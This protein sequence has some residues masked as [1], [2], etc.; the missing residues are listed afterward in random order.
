[1]A[2]AAGFEDFYRTDLARI[3]R[4]CALVTLDRALA[5]DIVDESFTR[6][7]SK[8][9]AIQNDEHAGG[10]VFKT[11]MRLCSKELRKKARAHPRPATIEPNPIARTL[12]SRDLFQ[13]LAALPLRQR[14]AVVLRD[15]AG[16]EAK[17]VARTIGIRESTVRVHL[18]RGR[19]ALRASLGAKEEQ[20]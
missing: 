3:V 9:G 1:M 16:F 19:E 15:W 6:V 17:E 14:Q 20:G 18:A 13:A 11:A 12:V 5:E 2:E 10:F 7:W 8:W 4:A